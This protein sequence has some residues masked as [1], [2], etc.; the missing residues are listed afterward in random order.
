M[1]NNELLENWSEVKSALLT[2]LPE[3]KK[4]IVGQVLENQKQYMLSETAA[5]GSVG[6]DSIA[7]FRK[8]MLPMIRRVI[9][10]TIA[11]ELVGVQPMTGPV[12]LIYSLRYTYNDAMAAPG[13]LGP[14]D[15]TFANP[16][17]S[18]AKGSEA[19][20]NMNAIR[21][22]Y[23][24][25]TDA[26]AQAAGANSFGGTPITG[27]P[28]G[29]GWGS[30][31]DAAAVGASGAAGSL[32]GGGGSFLEGSGGRRMGLQVV[33]QA[34]EAKTRK[35]Q[36]GWTI[37]AMQD[38][39]NQHGLDLENELTTAMSAEIVQEIDNEIITD[40]IAL[41]GTVGSWDGSVPATAGYYKPTFVG[42]RLANL[43]VQINYLANEIARKTRK[44]AGNWI[45]VSPM[46]VSV[47]Q[48]AAKSV[49][50]P[51]VEGSFKGPNNTMLVGTLNGTI[52]VYSYLWNQSIVDG[53]SSGGY[54]GT[55]DDTILIGYKGGNGE[56]DTGYF[57][58]PYIPLMSTGTI[59]NPNTFQ[60]TLG[61]M[62]RIGKAQLTN[63]ANSLG[64]SSDYYGK[65]VVNS[66]SLV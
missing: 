58:C 20:G 17:A 51:A 6:T 54:D 45:V 52:K 46:I 18:I 37:E 2:G 57:Y 36:A 53:Y 42:D 1:K 14:T 44:G 34:V 41:A 10:S 65:L 15:A 8:I 19:F 66:L 31:L 11:T 32:H 47:L 16:T 61:L 63:T 3:R 62:T 27:A 56:T 12:G 29:S 24:G 35:L 43:G 9:P 7:G 22:F 21:R 28:I 38:L 40:L 64:N 26:G 5:D 30:A 55:G 13:S 60:P 4:A 49:F 48:T 50:A 39:Q 33:S 25:A 59:F 23:S